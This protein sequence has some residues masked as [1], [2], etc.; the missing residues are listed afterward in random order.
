M[1]RNIIILSTGEVQRHIRYRTVNAVK[2][3]RKWSSR[4][5][6]QRWQAEFTENERAR[7]CR[8]FYEAEFWASKEAEPRSL[9]MTQETFD[10]WVKLVAFCE[11]L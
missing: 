9:R 6:K 8:I 11:S 3:S 2:R 5:R 10:L 1:T 4:K 7:T